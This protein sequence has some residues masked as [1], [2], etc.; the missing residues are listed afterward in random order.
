[1]KIGIIGCGA[2]GS[3]YACFFSSHDFDVSVIDT[4]KQHTNKITSTGLKISGPKL[5][6][7]LKTIKV[8]KNVKSL[9]NADLIIIAT[10]IESLDTVCKDLKQIRNSKAQ[11]LFIQNGIGSI[12]IINKY[13][14][15]YFIGIAEG[16]G[17][18]IIKPGHVHH[19]S[20]RQ[21]RI[22]HLKKN[23]T[24]EISTIVKVW[25]KAGFNANKYE[26]IN[27]LIWE[28]FLCNV[29]LS[30]PCTAFECTIGDLLN[31]KHKLSIA[32]GCLMEA[33]RL[34]LKYQINFSFKNPISYGLSFAKLMPKAKPSMFLDFLNRKK[35]EIDY[36][37]GAVVTL[38]KKKG[39]AAPYNE[40][41]TEI[42]KTKEIEF[43]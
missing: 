34:G 3:V 33:Y 37:N 21:I 36:I 31:S 40:T 43:A 32:K 41:L 18:S 11:F 13:F 2:M 4:W 28:K 15:N 19:N 6:K 29:F 1:M 17:A 10:K 39:L 22:G 35:S 7:K 9:K 30:A 26:D 27:Q 8:I 12:P 38:S 23:K 14:S 25:K 42:I 16:F 5:N 24:K 20:M